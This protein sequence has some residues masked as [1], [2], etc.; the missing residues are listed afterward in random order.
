M[1]LQ[2]SAITFYGLV[3][4]LS[5]PFWL[6]GL[7]NEQIPGI[8]PMGLPVS[9]LMAV[10]PLAA[11]LILTGKNNGRSGVGELFKKTSDYGKI[12]NRI[13]Y[14]PIVCTMPVVMLLSY[15]VMSFK[16]MPLPEVQIEVLAIPVNISLFFAGAVAEELGW[17]GYSMPLLNKLSALKAG[18]VLGAIWAVWHIVPYMQANRT[19]E[20]IVWQCIFTVATRILIVWIY[21]NT[22]GSVFA[23]S[24]FHAVGN[25]SVSLFPNNGSHYNPS[26]AGTILIIPALIVI[27][28]WGPQTMTGKTNRPPSGNEKPVQ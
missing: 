19:A 3:F 22:G 18:A 17:M 27:F 21:C 20:W 1:R 23:A 28:I 6:L 10:C 13:W 15:G 26:I 24:L 16:R 12:K 9:A 25:L 7:I 2:S 8:L 11:A 5:V 4:V 14:V